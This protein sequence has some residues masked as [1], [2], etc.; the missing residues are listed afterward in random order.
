MHLDI[1]T[2]GLEF[3]E[4]PVVMPD[5]SVIVC[6]IAGRRITRVAPDGRKTVPAVGWRIR[7]EPTTLTRAVA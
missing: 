2:D 3:P 1:I 5:G 7:R 4:G 6:E